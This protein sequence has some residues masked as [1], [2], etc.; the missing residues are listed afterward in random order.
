MPVQSQSHRQGRLDR[1]SIDRADRRWLAAWLAMFVAGM[2]LLAG[3]HRIYRLTGPHPQ[4]RQLIRQLKHH[5]RWFIPGLKGRRPRSHLL[6]PPGADATR[7]A[8][9]A[10]TSGHDAQRAKA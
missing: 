9:T 6:G 1:D 8:G 2:L 3:I 5:A 7:Y 10:R 4:V